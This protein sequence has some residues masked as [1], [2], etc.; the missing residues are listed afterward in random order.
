[1]SQPAGPT[2][3]PETPNSTASGSG[4]P[5]P[6]FWLIPA[7][8]F[9]LGLLLA[10]AVMTAADDTDDDTPAVATAPTVTVV[11]SAAATPDRT[12]TVPA[13]CEHGLERARTALST[14]GEAGEALRRLD[15][16]RLQELL[17]QLQ[18]AQREVD[19]LAG[20]CRQETP[21]RN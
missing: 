13:S 12:I 21:D 16:G 7:A 2:R 4:R 19:A 3:P 8:T 5:R 14:A 6:W 11:P 1:M 20:Q 10:G 9:V 15:T 18:A 17:N